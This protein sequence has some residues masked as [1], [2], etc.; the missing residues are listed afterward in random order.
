V[1]E[2]QIADANSARS[3]SAVLLGL[4]AVTC[5]SLTLP[6][7]R[8]AV[9]ELGATAVGLGRAVV[10]AALAAIVL[11]IRRERLPA[12]K[13]WPGL[14]IVSLGVIVGFPIC[15]SFAMQRLPASHAAVLVGLMPAATAVM[16]VVRAHE[17]PP[18]IFWLGCAAGVVAVLI[19]AAV[20]GAGA[21]Q[22]ADALLLAAVTLGGL[23]YAE[24][25]RLSREIGGWRVICWALVLSAPIL[26]V[27]VVLA[28]PADVANASA[29]AW[30]GLGYVSLVSMFAA[31]FAW[32]AALARGGVARIGQLQLIQPVLT[33]GWSAL[34]LEE[35]IH[36][37][38]IAAAL[39]VIATAALATRLGRPQAS[40]IPASVPLGRG[41][42]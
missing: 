7:T 36:A 18:K 20:E 39:L 22:P 8:A 25:G 40:T 21:P 31:F 3:S 35:T 13:Y 30:L 1:V 19:F 14:A 37:S 32:Y 27:P 29:K 24:G 15:T 26:L 38:T 11:A 34:F 23:G 12:S 42:P 5:F 4:F 16:A 28:W 17:R 33:L 10:A 9:P 6:A 41:L 2:S